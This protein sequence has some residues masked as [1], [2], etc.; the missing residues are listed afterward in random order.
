M[1]LIILLSGKS[2]RFVEAGY[3]EK[4]FIKVLGKY[5]IEHARD[6]Y[7]DIPNGDIFFIVRGDDWLAQTKLPNLFPHSKVKWIRPND[8]GPV[9]SILEA[10]LPIDDD[11]EVI[12]SYCDFMNNWNFRDFLKYCRSNNLDGCITTHKGFHPHRL[13]N[14]SFAFLRNDGNE[15]LE[16]R[17]K[18]PFTD[19]IFNEHA[20]NGAYYFARFGEMKR[21]FSVLVGADERSH[22]EFYVTMPYNLML[23]F[24]MKIHLYETKDFI[25]FGTPRDIELINAWEKII[26]Y[27]NPVGDEEVLNLFHYW[28]RSI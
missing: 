13:Y 1:K 27:S 26:K 18:E 6:M 21:Y 9:F 14:K 20:S 10:A 19:N 25:C 16:V 5:I 28:D 24:G 3:P 23:E 8:D 4:P 17:E 11:E 12:I 22:G 7:P 15:V 2:K